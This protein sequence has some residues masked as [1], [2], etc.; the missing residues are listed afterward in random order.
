MDALYQLLQ[1]VNWDPQLFRQS[2]PK[3]ECTAKA[4]CLGCS[5]VLGLLGVEAFANTVK[6]DS[7]SKGPKYALPPLVRTFIYDYI[8]AYNPLGLG[9]VAGIQNAVEA[10]FSGQGKCN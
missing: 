1:T 9:Q 5:A 7:F 3:V 4:C 8:V 6:S 10:R 2:Y